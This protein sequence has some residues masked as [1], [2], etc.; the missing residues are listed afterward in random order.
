[1]KHPRTIAAAALLLA[2]CNDNPTAPVATTKSMLKAGAGPSLSS[3]AVTASLDFS[4]DL[5][6][7]N[8]RV[9]PSLDDRAAAEQ[10]SSALASLSAH[11][12]A[13]D[14]VAASADIA[15]ARSQ[16][17]SDVG[18]AADLGNIEMVLDLI[19]TSL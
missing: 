19:E 16:L 6:S 18:S 3:T 5:E 11:L 7:L 13:G 17:K 10:I 4:A 9:V 12:S 8:S 2:A 1:M 14:R 15:A